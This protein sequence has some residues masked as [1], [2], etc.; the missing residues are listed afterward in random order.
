MK[1]QFD[2]PTDRQYENGIEKV[3]IFPIQHGKYQNGIAWSGITAVNERPSGAEPNPLYADNIKYLNLM[4]AE[5]FAATVEAYGYPMECASCFGKTEIAEGVY[6]GQQNRQ[7]FGLVYRTLCS[8]AEDKS[9][10]KVHV[11]F[12][13]VASPSERNNQSIGDTQEPVSLSWEL[14]T[15]KQ[16]IPNF[17]PS[18][19]L[20]LDSEK[21]KKAGFYN[22]LKFFEDTFY[23][24]DKTNSSFLTL[25]QIVEVIPKVIYLRDS[26]NNAIL[27]SNGDRI[28]STV[29]D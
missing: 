15:D 10:Y 23:G 20:V 22:L 24:T 5:E 19:C 16:A 14:N 4:S 27:D 12:N 21:L 7:H 18:C 9:E 29:Y 26:D 25:E 1:L 11:L 13:C 17:K 3:A 2:R 28:Q 8:D 6:I